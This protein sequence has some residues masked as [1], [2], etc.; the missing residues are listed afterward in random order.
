LPLIIVEHVEETTDIF[1]WQFDDRRLP[2][3]GHPPPEQLEGD[4]EAVMIIF[5][6]KKIARNGRAIVER[7]NVRSIL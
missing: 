4:G 3:D 6:H 5:G 2:I 7:I 1:G